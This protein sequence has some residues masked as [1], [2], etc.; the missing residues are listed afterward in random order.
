[1]RSMSRTRTRAAAAVVEDAPP[2]RPDRKQAILLAAE[3][4]FASHG[5][6]AVSLRQISAPIRIFRAEQASVCALRSGDAG[7]SEINQPDR[8][9][10]P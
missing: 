3:K 6:H 4:L 9:V 5:Y 7:R 2:E 1:M 8:S 10:S